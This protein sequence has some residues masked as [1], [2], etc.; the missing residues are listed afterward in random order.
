MIGFSIT[1]YPQNEIV[2]IFVNLHGKIDTFYIKKYEN[3]GIEKEVQKLI[4]NSSKTSYYSTRY[5]MVKF[6]TSR[7]VK[8][9]AIIDWSISVKFWG[10]DDTEEVRKFIFFKKHPH[11]IKNMVKFAKEVRSRYEPEKEER[12]RK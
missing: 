1:L 11:R 5:Y 12:R 9:W 10:L 7:N 3:T 4:S 8:R 6:L 2:K